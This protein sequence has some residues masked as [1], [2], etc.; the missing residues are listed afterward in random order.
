MLYR[1]WWGRGLRRQ[2]FNLPYQEALLVDELFVLGAVLEESR[3]EAQ[4]FLSVTNQNLLYRVGFVWI[5]NKDLQ[6]LDYVLAG[7]DRISY[8]EDVES[9]VINHFP[10]VSQ[11]PHDDLEV[12]SRVNILCHDIVVCPVEQNL[13]QQLDRL[14]L[15]DVAV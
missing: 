2:L 8:L 10:V 14:T 6:L 1:R 4:E 5:R 15:R 7:F 13:T 3:K 11:Q 12:I 9:L